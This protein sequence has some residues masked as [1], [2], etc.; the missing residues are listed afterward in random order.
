L[1]EIA[2]TKVYTH[3]GSLDVAFYL[4]FPLKII[5]ITLDYFEVCTVLH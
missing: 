2:E 3:T 4:L 5:D 1:S